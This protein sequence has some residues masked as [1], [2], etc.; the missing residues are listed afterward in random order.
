MPTSSCDAENFSG[1]NDQNPDLGYYKDGILKLFVSSKNISFPG[2]NAS[3]TKESSN[4]MVGG[5]AKCGCSDCHYTGSAPLFSSGI[6]EGLS[7][8]HRER[9]KALLDQSVTNLN[10]QADDNLEIVV[11]IHRIEKYLKDEKK[12]PDHSC[13]SDEKIGERLCQKQKMSSSVISADIHRLAG[14]IGDSES[15]GQLR[16]DFQEFVQNGG[17]PAE[18]T[19]RKYSDDLFVKFTRL[20]Q[21]LEEYLDAIMSNCREMTLI[22]KQQLRRRISNLPEKAL[23]RVLEIIHQGKLSE[24]DPC[25]LF[26]IDLDREDKVTLWRLYYYVE[27]VMRMKGVL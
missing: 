7:S 22:E 9:L 11:A 20:E 12:S 17:S 21:Q 25:D 15:H 2:C 8:V 4:C 3:R 13:E 19:L 14:T 10:Q 16:L 5:T 18:I 1:Q 23:D 26:H 24:G 6:G 27:T